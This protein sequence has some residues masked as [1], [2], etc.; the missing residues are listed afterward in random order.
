MNAARTSAAALASASVH[1]ARVRRAFAFAFAAMA[2]WLAIGTFFYHGI[3]ELAWLDA[4]HQAA[5][6]AAG[7]GPVK[8]IN[9]SLGKVFDSFYALFS[10][11]VMLGAAGYLFAPF[12]HRILRRFHI[13]DGK[14]E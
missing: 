13:E 11:F 2:I 10:G 1:Y 3:E 7:M 6:L 9:T 12:A 5:L 4:F 8:E 14:S